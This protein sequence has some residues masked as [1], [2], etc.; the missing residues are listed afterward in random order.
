MKDIFAL[1]FCLGLAAG[2]NNPAPASMSD[3]ASMLSGS[4]ASPQAQPADGSTRQAQPAAAAAASGGAGRPAIA[5][6]PA[7]MNK[8]T[9]QP[10]AAGMSARPAP[11]DADAGAAPSGKTLP[12]LC[13]GCA[14]ETRDPADMTAHLHHVHLNVKSREQSVQFYQKYFHAERVLLNATT[15]ALHVAPTLILLD[16]QP[17]APDSNLPTALQHMGWGAADTGAWY[18]QAHAQGIEPDTRGGTL[19]NTMTDTKW[20]HVPYK[21]GGPALIDLMAGQTQIM[22]VTFLSGKPLFRSGKLRCLAVS[23]GRKAG[24]LSTVP[25]WKPR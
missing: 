4:A 15:E 10:A 9:S 2:C 24:N 17:S 7:M 3:A 21:G 22:F 14:Q 5:R 20:V 12:A 13:S 19:F 18:A 1:V 16:E 8:P 23:S 11:D 6:M 25:P